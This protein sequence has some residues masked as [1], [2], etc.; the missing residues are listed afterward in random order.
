MSKS[1]AKTIF[2]ATLLVAMLSL[3][4]SCEPIDSVGRVIVWSIESGG[5]VTDTI[6]PTSLFNEATDI[7]NSRFDLNLSPSD[8]AV[9]DT[10]FTYLF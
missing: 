9:V 3:L 7:A 2:A 8:D 4:A 10:V 1:T 5:T 6:A